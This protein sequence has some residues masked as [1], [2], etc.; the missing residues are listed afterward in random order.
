MIAKGQFDGHLQCVYL[1]CVAVGASRQHGLQSLG[2]VASRRMPPP[3]HLPSLR[4]E[5]GGAEP[6]VAIVPSGSSGYCLFLFTTTTT[7]TTNNLHLLK[8]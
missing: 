5:Q 1:R 3:A 7:T 2:K 8:L 6:S 4:S